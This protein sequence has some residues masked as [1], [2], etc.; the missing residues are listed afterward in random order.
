MAWIR[1]M[2][3]AAANRPINLIT[4]AGPDISLVNATVSGSVINYSRPAND[5]ASVTF[6]KRYGIKNTDALYVE[7]TAGYYTGLKLQMS[8][9]GVTWS[10]IKTYSSINGSF[11]D[12][13]SLAAYAGQDILIKVVLHGAYNAS[14]TINNV[15]I[16]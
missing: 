1:A 6:L 14:G 16:I 2:G 11:N 3:G 13:A 12:T 4:D 15:S 7:I 9:D 8:T 5:T 10:D